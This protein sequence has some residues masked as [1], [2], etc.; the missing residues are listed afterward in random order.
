MTCPTCIDGLGC[1]G[2]CVLR[3]DKSQKENK[4]KKECKP[5]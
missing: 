1:S 2:K 5:K 3:N 4:N